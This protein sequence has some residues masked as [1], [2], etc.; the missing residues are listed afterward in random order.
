MN[1]I[2]NGA[3][4]LMGIIYLLTSDVEGEYVS[5]PEIRV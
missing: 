5:P 4:K 2:L 3:N 1:T